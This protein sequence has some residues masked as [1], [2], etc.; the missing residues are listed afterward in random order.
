MLGE[1][2]IG[3][4]IH[5]VA[6]VDV[7]VK[8]LQC[9]G[10]ISELGVCGETIHDALH[11]RRPDEDGSGIMGVEARIKGEQ[12]FNYDEWRRVDGLH[13]SGIS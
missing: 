13:H 5:D 9:G 4:D 10:V 8:V 1:A 6:W 3:A 2:A 11:V 12:A 7:R